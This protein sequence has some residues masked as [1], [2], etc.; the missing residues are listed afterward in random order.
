M[1]LEPTPTPTAKP[2]NPYSPVSKVNIAN[3]AV[4]SAVNL[5]SKVPQNIKSAYNAVKTAFSKENVSSAGKKTVNLES[6]GLTFENL[7][8]VIYY[9]QSYNPQLFYVN[10][11]NV[12]YSSYPSTGKVVSVSLNCTAAV[13]QYDAVMAKFDEYKNGFDAA[14]DAVTIIK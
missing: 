10:W 1:I 11:N 3:D 5:D 7:M 14:E 13:S 2:G 6:F 9:V 8:D 4:K 12:S